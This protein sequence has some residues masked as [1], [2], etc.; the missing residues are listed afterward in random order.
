MFIEEG[1]PYVVNF[2]LSCTSVMLFHCELSLVWIV[3]EN[4]L[5]FT[6]VYLDCYLLVRV[7]FSHDFR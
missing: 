2:L 4:L 3:L 6:Q 7:F 1:Y 5:T